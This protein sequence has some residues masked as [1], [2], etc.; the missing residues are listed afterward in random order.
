MT[1]TQKLTVTGMLF[2][3]GIIL[4][5]ATAHGLGMSGGVLLPMHIPVF[6]CG[7]L[8]GPWYGLFC[9]IF[10]PVINSLLTGMPPIYP[11]MPIMVCELATYG[12]I[13]GIFYHKTPL[14][15]K[16]IGVYVAMLIAMICGRVVYGLVFH[17]LLLLNPALKVATVW[18]AIATG[19]P[20]IIV[21]LLL[22]PA[23]VFA[24]C[25]FF[26]RENTT[27]IKSAKNLIKESKATCVV[28]KKGEIINVESG[29]GISPIIALYEKGLFKESMVVDKI[30]GKAAAMIMVLGGVKSCYGITMSQCAVDFLKTNGVKVKYDECVK[31]I[32]NRKG[33][34]ICPMEQTVQEIN[35]PQQAYEALKAKLKEFSQNKQ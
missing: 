30:I 32:I 21:Q 29:N 1:R 13:S 18:V 31:N 19:V 7:L 20:G 27:A 23:V 4:P 5:F 11:L 25:G 14:K 10:L 28:I 2:A 15:N 24:T 34:G 26:R 6:I 33:D 22:V 8:C 35:S 16:K 3:I 17:F 9:G 12:L